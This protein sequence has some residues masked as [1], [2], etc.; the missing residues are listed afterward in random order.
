MWKCR[1]CGKA[2]YFAE[3]KTSLGYDWHPECLRC[4]ECA[5]ILNPGQH[6]EH[7]G[8]PYCN[9]PCYSVLFGPSLY[10]H[11]SR[12]ES[13][14]SFGKP[15]EPEFQQGIEKSLIEQK[16]KEYNAYFECKQPANVINC[17][18]RNGK[19]VL[20][21]SL[22]IYWDVSK[23]L[24]LKE[25]ND[26]RI[27]VLRRRTTY[28]KKRT[29]KEDNDKN[30]DDSSDGMEDVNDN[31]SCKSN[32][33]PDNSR[34]IH[35]YRTL[36]SKCLL[37]ENKLDSSEKNGTKDSNDVIKTVDA[38]STTDGTNVDS[39]YES[40]KDGKENTVESNNQVKSPTRRNIVRGSRVKL[41]RR[42]SI[43]GHYYNRETC[44]F[45]PVQGSLTS[46]WLTS[47]VNTNE[48]INLLLDKFKVTNEPQNFS[49]F[50]VRDN[51]EC[52]RIMGN[53][54]P[55]LTR[56]LLGPDENAVRF[57]ILNKD[58]T[59]ISNEVAQYLNFSNVELQVF[60]E[61]YHEQEQNE[62][63]KVKNK[64]NILK[65][66]LEQLIESKI[67]TTIEKPAIKG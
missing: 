30:T 47:L 55:L 4:E 42:C 43:N 10:G 14:K 36:S 3:R 35:N 53:E 22:R 8:V 50:I 25:E 19:L 49:L 51:G 28:V 65:E 56:V 48:V 20:E 39:D 34:F 26:D 59:E 33:K 54:Y 58:N 38:A 27:L 12:I 37:G 5:K 11:G 23:E 64:Y 31:E 60:L 61:K 15:K 67:S 41:K 45:T 7:K 2:V 16:L 18:E 17:R 29:R 40:I 62:I 63:E 6:A 9:I 52:R 66:T 57:Y 21:G 13:H 1:K 24:I 44:V 32:D 46:V